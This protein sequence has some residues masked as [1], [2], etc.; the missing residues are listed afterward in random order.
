[1]L[2]VVNLVGISI[3]YTWLYN[4][5]RGSTLLA[6][7]FHAVGNT[8]GTL[9]GALVPAAGDP[10]VYLVATGLTWLAAGVVLWAG[11]RA[12]AGGPVTVPNPV[13]PGG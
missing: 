8:T 12:F 10:Q 6:I 4:G 1:M 5:T 9:L 13:E 11:S 7:L 3:V 2:L